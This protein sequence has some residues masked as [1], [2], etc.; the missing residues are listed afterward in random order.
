MT[1]AELDRLAEI[2]ARALV[3]R[4][5]ASDDTGRATTW[6]PTPVRP[7]PPARGGE[8]P[9]WS[10]AAQDLGDVAPSRD[11]DRSPRFRAATADLTRATRAAAAGKG[12][13]VERNAHAPERRL[14]RQRPAN[15]PAFDVRVGVSNRHIHLSEADARTL[16]GS[17][18]LSVARLL[19]QPG[20][21]AAAETV[22]AHGPKGSLESIRVVGPARTE[23]QLE[24][25][26]SDAAV[27][28]VAPPVATSGSLADSIG[29][30]TLVGPAGRVELRRGVIVAARHLHLS[31]TDA[32]RWGLR[33]GDRLDV[34]CG[35]G[36]R[37]ATLHDVVVRAGVGHATELH[38]DSDEARAVGVA[39]GDTATVVA[40]H[41][42]GPA[43]RP[44]ITERDVVRLAREGARIPAN[45]LLTPSA[46][47]RASALGILDR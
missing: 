22:A 23:T 33:D 5:H 47:D 43:K 36:A 10:G 28:G 3:E 1:D 18:P 6:L 11:R 42:A 19:N 45:A 17:G 46:R 27:L 38:L 40:W 2:I 29:G 25:A 20:Q 9:S 30:V 7:M 35:V 24:I 37:A 12:P 31:P 13:P 26:L 4:P 14:T 41:A 8:P 21:F 34:R 32:K 15:A 39:T 44:L 16:F